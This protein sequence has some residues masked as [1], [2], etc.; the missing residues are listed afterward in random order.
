MCNIKVKEALGFNHATMYN[1]AITGDIEIDFNNKDMKSLFMLGAF[2]P[3]T[4]YTKKEI[5]R[6]RYLMKKLGYRGSFISKDIEPLHIRLIDV[7]PLD[8]RVKCNGR[9]ANKQDLEILS[10]LFV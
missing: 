4:E 9:W 6:M 8:F 3:E 10:K 2:E 1:D 7:F 5:R